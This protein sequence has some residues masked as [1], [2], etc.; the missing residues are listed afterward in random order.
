ML[1][2]EQFYLLKLME[3]CSE[4]AQ[5]CSKQIQF[6]ALENEDAT[7][8]DNRTRLRAELN[9]LLAV[10][11]VLIELGQIR[12]I[13]PWELQAKK[14]TKREKILKFL[15]YSQEL[16]T[17]ETRS[18]EGTQHLLKAY[19][20][21]CSLHGRKWI[22]HK[23]AAHTIPYCA[24]CTGEETVEGVQVRLHRERMKHQNEQCLCDGRGC[25][26]CCGPA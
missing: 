3:E 5:R 9:D 16:K 19:P 20:P 22:V 25:T 8:E 18:L 14:A 17:V 12:E 15:K 1:S 21:E 24:M 10:T 6:G 2:L 13:A 7:S 11:D 26:R 4:V 23:D